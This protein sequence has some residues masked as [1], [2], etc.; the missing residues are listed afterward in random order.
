[1]AR[2]KKELP[3]FNPQE[4][5]AG[6]ESFD[7]SQY[8]GPPVQIGP[9]AIPQTSKEGENEPGFMS[10]LG[11]TGMAILEGITLIPGGVAD[12]FRDLTDFGDIDVSDEEALRER[13]AREKERAEYVQK[14]KGK[15]F[16]GVADAMTSM[17]YSLATMGASVV[18]SAPFG[19]VTPPGIAA[20]AAAGG[21]VAYGA[22]KTQYM[23]Q[24][25]DKTTNDLGRRPTPEE[26]K[27]ITD[28]H[29]GLASEYG[30]WEAIPEAVS[31]VLMM[32]ILGPLGKRMLQGGVGK[33]AKRV[34]GLYG[35]ELGTETVTQMGQGSVEARSGMRDEAPGVVEAFKEVAPTTMWQ[36]TLMAGGHKVASK[37]AQMYDNRVRQGIL[38]ALPDEVRNYAEALSTPELR[39]LQEYRAALEADNAG[40]GN[41]PSAPLPPT[42]PTVSAG[43]AVNPGTASEVFS[44]PEWEATQAHPDLDAEWNRQARERGWDHLRDAEQRQQPPSQTQAALDSGQAVDL[45]APQ[46]AAIPSGQDMEQPAL[47]V[48]TGAIPMGTSAPTGPAIV[49]PTDYAGEPI[50]TPYTQ[51]QALPYGTGGESYAG[52]WTG[53]ASQLSYPYGPGIAQGIAGGMIP[54]QVEAAAPQEPMQIPAPVIDPTLAQAPTIQAPAPVMAPMTETAPTLHA[55]SPVMEPQAA[56]AAE[57]VQAEETSQPRSVAQKRQDILAQLP[58]EWRNKVRE[59]PLSVL[60][61]IQEGKTPQ[62]F[63]KVG[64]SDVYTVD[65][66]IFVG[67]RKV[68]QKEAQDIID[69]NIRYHSNPNMPAARGED[70]ASDYTRPLSDALQ[71]LATEEKPAP[72]KTVL[73]QRKE[74]MHALAAAYDWDKLKKMPL[75]K[76]KKLYAEYMANKEKPGVEGENTASV[77]PPA[78]V[79]LP[80]R[81]EEADATGRTGQETGRTESGLEQGNVGS[82]VRVSDGNTPRGAGEQKDRGVEKNAAEGRGHT[83]VKIPNHADEPV[84][85]RLMEADDVQASHLPGASF[86]KNPKYVFENERRY[87]DE[88]ASQG[89]VLQNAQNLDPSFLLE[90]VDA[91]HGAPVVDQE[92]NVLGGNGRAMSISHA[93]EKFPD[94]ADTYRAA[95]RERAA[96]LGLNPSDVDAMQRPVLVRQLDRNMSHKERQDLVTALNDT[97]TD[98]K[99]ARASGK[100]RGDRLSEKTLQALGKGLAEAD[101]LRQF[102]DEPESVDVVEMLIDDGVIQKTERNAYVGP[103]GLLNPD[104]KR[105]VEEALRGRVARSYDAL[106]SLPGA[107]VGKIDAAIPHLLVAE[108]VGGKWNITEHMRDAIDL[109][110]EYKGGNQDVAVFLDQTDMLKGGKTP[111]ER[112]SNTAIDFFKMALD[113]KKK[114]FVSAFAKFAGAAKISAEAGGLPGIGKT[115]QQ[116]ARDYLGVELDEQPKQEAAQEKPKETP[117]LSDDEKATAQA[118]GMTEEEYAARKKRRSDMANAAIEGLGN[119][120]WERDELGAMSKNVQGGLRGDVNPLGNRS[121]IARYRDGSLSAYFGG[122]PIVSIPVDLDVYT[123]ERL[124]ENLDKRVQ[125]WADRTAEKAA[126]TAAP[127][128]TEKADRDYG[129]ADNPN[130]VAIADYFAEQFANGKGYKT[131]VEARREVGNLLG[132]PAIPKGTAL[133]AVDEAIELGVVKAARR[134]VEDMRAQNKGDVDIFRALVDLYQRQPNLGTRTSTSVAQ[135][136]YSTPVPLSFLA[137]R[138]A[139]IGKNSRVYEPTAGNGSLL[140]EASPN[141]AAVNELNGGRA[142]RLRSQGFTVTQHDATNYAPDGKVDVVIENPPFGRIWNDDHTETVEFD[143]DGFATK[144]IDQAIVAKSLQSLKDNGKGRAVLIIGGKQGGPEARKTKY[145]AASQVNFWSHIFDNYHV[146]DHFSIDGKMYSRQ[147]ASYPIDVIVLDTNGTSADRIYPGAELP[148]MYSSFEELEE[149][150]NER[151]MDRAGAGVGA[152]N[153]GSGLVQEEGGGERRGAAAD[154]R[155]ASSESSGNGGGR[156]SELQGEREGAPGS[157]EGNAEGTERPE[158]GTRGERAGNRGEGLGGDRR[159]SGR[160]GSAVG[161]AAVNGERELSDSDNLGGRP[162]SGR[163]EEP[164]RMGQA[165]SGLVA[166][167]KPA[168]KKATASQPKSTEFQTPYKKTSNLPSMGTLVPK[169]MATAV[170]NAMKTLENE[171]GKIDDYVAGELGYKPGELGNY[172]AAEQIDALGLAI[173]NLANG[174]GFIIGDQTGIGKGR[175]NAAIIRWAKLHGKTPVFIT[176]SN[177]LY[178]DMVRDL[179]DI[180]MDGF[181]P[182]PTNPDLTGESAIPLPDGR[183]LTTKNSAKHSALLAQ[184]SRD[185]LGDYDAVFTT[186]HQLSNDPKGTRRRFLENIAPNAVF[187]LDESHN[188]GSEKASGGRSSKKDEAANDSLASFIRKLL[189]SCPNGTFYSSATYAKRPDLMDLYS[190]TDMRFAVNDIKTLG[191]AIARGG[192]PMQQVVAAELADAGQYIRRE[193]TWEGA[194]VESVSV[195]TDVARADASAEAL[196]V[197][198]EFDRAK[199]EALKKIKDSEASHGGSASDN[200]SANESGIASANFSSIMHNVINQGLLAQKVEAIVDAADAALKRGEKPVITLSNTMESAIKE[201]MESKAAKAGDPIDITFK[202]MYLRYLEKARTI[203]KKDKKGNIIEKRLLTDEELGPEAVR[204]YNEAREVISE[205]GLDDLPLSFI[206]NIQNGLRKRGY[207][208]GEITGRSLGIDYSGSQPVISSINNSSKS[209]AK[210]IDDFNSGKMDA[211]ILNSSGSTGISLHA[212]VNFKDQRRRTMIIAQPDLNIDVFMQTLGRIFRTGQVVPPKYQLLFTDI[213]AEKRPAAILSRKMASLNANTSA[214][215]DSDA[216]FKNIPDFMNKYGDQVAKQVMKEVPELHRRMGSPLDKKAIQDAGAMQCLTGYIPLLPVKDQQTVYDLLET[217]YNE[218][219]AQHEAM[220]TLDLEAKTLP[221]DAKLLHEEIIQPAKTDANVSKSPFAA[222][223]MLG[224][225]DVKRLGH[226]FS[227]AKVKELVQKAKPLDI[228]AESEKM[229]AFA[230]D[231]LSR[232]KDEE[233]RES[234]KERMEAAFSAFNGIVRD[235]DIGAPVMVNSNKEQRHI[236]GIVIGIYRNEKIENPLALSSWKMDV[237]IAD[238]AK[239]ITFS[240]SQLAKSGSEENET[241]VDAYGVSAPDAYEAFDKG[242]SESRER[243]YIATGNILSAFERLKVG[244][245]IQFEDHDGNIV[246]GLQMPKDAKLS[247]L[248]DSVDLPLTPEQAIQFLDRL[249]TSI[250]AVKTEDKNFVMT[251][252]NNGY[253]IAVPASKKEGAQYYLNGSILKAAGEDFVKRGQSMVLRDLTVRQATDV[254]NAMAAQGYGFVADN[255]KDVARQIVGQ[256]KSDEKPMASV[257]PGAHLPPVG[258]ARRGMKADALRRVADKLGSIAKNATAARVVQSFD[259]LP[260]SIREAHKNARTTL[261]GVFDPRSGAVYLVADNLA[262]EARAAEVWTHEQ[263]VHNGLRSIMTPGERKRLMGKLFVSMGGMGNAAIREVA[264]KYNLDPR[265]NAEARQTVMEEV[266]ASMAERKGKGLLKRA[267]G[268][269]WQR[270]VDA[271]RKAWNRIVEAISGRPSAMNATNIDELLT[272]L[273]RHVIDGAGTEN[274]GRRSAGQQGAF[275]SQGN[276]REEIGRRAWER[277]QK[278]TEN[279]GRQVDA[280]DPTASGKSGQRTLLTVSATPDVLQKLGALDLPM[281]MEPRNLAKILSD[282]EDHNLSKDLVKQLPQAIAEPI[283][284]FESATRADAFVVLTELKNNGRSVMV[285]VQLDRERQR[286]RVNDVASAYTRN[287][288]W[289]VGQIQDGRLLYKDQKKSLAWARTNGLQLPKVRRLPTRLSENRILT[290]DDVVKPSLWKQHS[291]ASTASDVRN[292]FLSN[293]AWLGR[294]SVK[295]EGAPKSQRGQSVGNITE[296]NGEDNTPLASLASSSAAI[297]D[298]VKRFMSSENVAAGIRALRKVAGRPVSADVEDILNNPEMGRLI[299]KKDIGWFGRLFKLPY[300]HA[301]DNAD[302]RRLYERQQQRGEE[303]MEATNKDIGGMSLLFDRDSKNRLNDKEMKQLATMIHKWDGKPIESLREIKKFRVTGQGPNGRDELEINPAYQRGFKDW[304]NEQPE[305]ERV[306]QAFQQVR[307]TL[308]R[309]FLKAYRRMAEMKEVADSE[310]EVYRTQ[311]GRI[312]NYFPHSRKGKYYVVARNSEGET[313]FRKHFDVPLGSSVREE[314]AKIVVANRGNFPGAKW[315]NP[316]EVDKLPDDILGAPID[317]QAMEQIIKAAAAKVGDQEQA[318]KIQELMLGSVSDILKSRGWGAHGI[319]RQNIAGYEMDDIKGVLYEYVSGLN[320]WLAKMDAARDF[321]QSLGKIDARK[322]PRLWEYSSTYVKDML[323]NSDKVDRFAANVKNVAFAWYLGAN[324]KT[325]IVNATQNPM[326]GIPRLD[327][328]CMGAWGGWFK[329]AS[330]SIGLH[331]TGHGVEGAK[332]LTADEQAMLEDLY[333]KGIVNA[334]YMDELQGQLTSSPVLKGWNKFIAMLGLPMAKVEVFNR[335]SLALAAY[336]A[337]KAGKW[338]PAAKK[339]FGFRTGEKLNNENAAKFAAMIVRDSHFE[340]GKGNLPE[341]LRSTWAGRAMSPVYTFRSFGGNMLNLWAR[342]LGKERDAGGLRFLAQ[343]LGMTIALGGLTS[344]PFYATISALCMAASGDDEDWTAKLRRTLPMENTEQN[345]LLYGLPAIA[346]VTLSGSLRMETFMT[347][348]LSK[349]KTLKEVMDLTVLNM[350]GVPYDMIAKLSKANE[351]RK[352]G[353]PYRAVE[354]LAPTFAANAMQAYRLATEGNISLKGKPI[355]DGEK[356]SLIEAAEKAAG[357]Q[358]V[359]KAESYERYLADKRAKDRQREK[360]QELADLFNEYYGKDSSKGTRLVKQGLDAWNKD[361]REKGRPSMELT[362]KDVLKSAKGKRTV[363]KPGKWEKMRER[364]RLARTGS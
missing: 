16:E 274:G 276:S 341:M 79:E 290:D 170:S 275:A 293:N 248:L 151:E 325:A 172:F 332:K 118:L 77:Q 356:L 313:V 200:R 180:G 359:S 156:G 330:D 53:G 102:F 133:K 106:A 55:P 197:I 208:V 265:K 96:S 203:T 263:V 57:P 63:G 41:G 141:N 358:P 95:I 343:N 187:I 331:Y 32:K 234:N 2:K 340:Y 168:T 304:L 296:G 176:C 270:I 280:F 204:L 273:G 326:V 111:R 272:A 138:L 56:P 179:A 162:E 74:I 240:F 18:A 31:N 25:L 349:A 114:D 85:F 209:K 184:V 297:G 47:P 227:S 20:G 283:M 277:L 333:G 347:E 48:G 229:R 19:F 160:N 329:A 247:E 339:Q 108:S 300:W 78:M 194:D 193:R 362:M 223:A 205:S 36:T 298:S 99:N 309:D 116:A 27:N 161:E 350:L 202:D 221:L 268:G 294:T 261:E 75:S 109:L 342:A 307:D 319:Q 88:P 103:D 312:H 266:V 323:R 17:P 1:M 269:A 182:L 113:A 213:P 278:D 302:F 87:H 279:W 306:K 285:A 218:L 264:E 214:A 352:V 129:T 33:F 8:A 195:K 258:K 292:P 253:N 105:I 155:G 153:A 198:M 171:H 37:A 316:R 188:G 49:T 100:S 245:V 152:G 322:T 185:G 167:E 363:R 207:T 117:A 252:G 282:K 345:M 186:Y 139:R 90:S 216:S 42:P 364:E 39:Q 132:G 124:A 93:Y 135:Q 61:K 315:E 210:T 86:Q 259:E 128:S 154:S 327:Q 134:T 84:T 178:A 235:F 173:H 122:V 251:L 157:R 289:Y 212:S 287:A 217:G 271:I 35:E 354:A 260:A 169:N 43:D 305:P 15:A 104:G 238:A 101:S 115:A 119:L 228:D 125:E 257:A 107:V 344:F 13:A 286:I 256:Q 267:E 30:A 196:H 183:S 165:D 336:R 230:K 353:N 355:G 89:K 26:W 23:R 190:K 310:L 231:R 127:A 40:N 11:N 82:D 311:F 255:N 67:G 71:S 147:G 143:I 361:M 28:A 262:S 44:G 220:G 174:A 291:S 334:A 142:E 360:K 24:L 5:M 346:G 126:E 112:Y 76:L 65:G 149:L 166:V 110:A 308:D 281:T 295:S 225:Y 29:E 237:A 191:E 236:P 314:W 249:G 215:K 318:K 94:K 4:F 97:F 46:Q 206:D 59:L 6:L 21:S 80:K 14:Y 303:R 224:E 335:A 222:A 201:Y 199:Q 351:A 73:E 72:Q 211:I 62:F 243:V 140:I 181:S 92:G 159:P 98:S 131:I 64:T 10:K 321:A 50:T 136:A 66:D 38:G 137:S 244:K 164:G 81:E 288:G 299:E 9:Q 320:G 246:P 130:T 324:L 34:G 144:E 328:F 226:P 7:P 239:K 148:R 12:T 177:T 91:N 45:L 58:E 123:P 54:Q 250:G 241:T 22:S 83:S 317:P 189:N 68:S 69:E 233:R 121:V 145:R 232:I 337:A 146:L 219:I 51:R 60:Q 301:K 158:H 163:G 70:Y 150:F 284:V 192:I 348:P 357:F 175:V 3:A 338:R 52:Q 242:Q 254:L 120:G